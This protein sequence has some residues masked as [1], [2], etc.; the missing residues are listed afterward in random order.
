MDGWMKLLSQI[1]R[2]IMGKANEK[3]V[4]TK[5]KEEGRRKEEEGRS[6]TNTPIIGAHIY[7]Y[8]HELCEQ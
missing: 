6:T 4:M 7:T 2:N 3:T 1:K 5:E 8:I